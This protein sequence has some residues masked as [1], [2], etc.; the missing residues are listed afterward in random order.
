MSEVAVQKEIPIKVDSPAHN[1]NI[2][3]AVQDQEELD[4]LMKDAGRSPEVETQ[5]DIKEDH[6]LNKVETKGDEDEGLTAEEKTFKKR[7]GDLRKHS[8]EK[9]KD[10]QSRLEKLEEQL[11]LAS[12]KELVLPKSTEEVEAWS[13][14]HPD[15]AAIVESIADKKATE[16]S[17]NLEKRMKE[18]EQVRSDAVREKAE[19]ELI[20]LHPDFEEIRNGDEFHNW[21]EEQ[22]KWVKDALYENMDDAKS[23]AR[24][25]DLYKQDKGMNKASPASSSDKAA[26]SSV[27]ART[28]STPE[29]DQAKKY[30]SESVVNRM[31][32][33]EYAQRSDEIMTAIRE[34]KFTYDMTKKT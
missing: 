27:K 15:V 10:L 6:Q 20:N 25:I 8:A 16:R 7:Y 23:V 30:L 31:S 3:R 2:A 26:A 11:Q 22:P 4:Q 19:A 32:P 34:G 24:V 14:Q 17:S 29:A 12:K 28:R 13:R 5:E 9:E 1:R 18:F 33:K 21:A